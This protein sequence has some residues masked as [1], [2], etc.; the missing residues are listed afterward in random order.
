[1]KVNKSLTK[2]D[3]SGNHKKVVL[4]NSNRLFDL[5]WNSIGDEGAKSL[6]EA[7]K[8]NDS[9]KEIYLYDRWNDQHIQV[10]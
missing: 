2:L 4:V 9:L 6:A 3:L 5:I 7:L 8:V 1:M 10:N